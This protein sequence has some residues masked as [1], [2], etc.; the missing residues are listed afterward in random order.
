MEKYN[1][2][3][4]QPEKL[5]EDEIRV[6]RDNRIGK[7]LRRANDILTG[8]VENTD[9]TIVIKAVANAMENAV[10]LA[11]LIKHRVK[12]LYQLNTINNI[13]IADEWEPLEE[14]LDHLV[15][16][17]ISTMLTIVLSKNPLNKSEVG[18]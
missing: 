9:N 2:I 10:K 14:G 8:K 5:P 4:R 1:R 18:Y 12:G 11:E 17:K 15:F 3:R 16:K 7:Y 13:E 6:R